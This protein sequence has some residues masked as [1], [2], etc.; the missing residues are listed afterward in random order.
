MRQARRTPPRRERSPSPPRVS[1]IRLPSEREQALFEAGIKLGGIFHQFIGVPVA[2]RTSASLER[3]IEE[4]VGLQ[5]FVRSV[6]VTID[7][8]QGGPTGTGRFGYRYLTAEMLSA[9]V[10]IG[11]GEATVRA[12]LSFRRDLNYPL[13]RVLSVRG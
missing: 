1:R 8:A 6:K 12:E 10:S 3:A 7:P 9:E 2:R 5:P 13:M 4:A 11:V